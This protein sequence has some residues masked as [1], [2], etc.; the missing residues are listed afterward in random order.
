MWFPGSILCAFVLFFKGNENMYYC[1]LANNLNQIRGYLSSRKLSQVSFQTPKLYQN[2]PNSVSARNLVMKKFANVL[3]TTT[4]TWMQQST[5]VSILDTVKDLL[6]LSIMIIA[7]QVKSFERIQ[8]RR[9]DLTHSW[10]GCRSSTSTSWR[11][12]RL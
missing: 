4:L 7:S 9:A 3:A 11:E 5:N 6:R 2:I 1:L 10:G 12:W 8:W